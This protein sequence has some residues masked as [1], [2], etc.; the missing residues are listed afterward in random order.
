MS[1]AAITDEV[2]WYR[3]LDRNQWNTLIASNLGWMFDGYETFALVVTVGAALRQ[4]LDRSQY[5]DIPFYAGIVIGLTLLGWGIGG[6]I[7]GVLAD[8]LGRKRTML[9]AILAYSIMTG[10]SAFAWDWLSFTVLRFLV[11]IAIGSEWVTGASIVSELWP[12]RARG[13]GVGLMQ[14]GFGIGFF[15]ASFAWLFVGAMGPNGWRYMF[16]IGVSPALMTLWVRRAIPE[17]ERWERV[18]H[19]RQA[20][21]EHRRRG[22]TLSAHDEALTRFTM[23]DLFAEPEIRRRVVLAFVMSL[24]TTFG[25]WGIGAWI[26]PFVTEAAARAGRD[27]QQWGSYAAMAYTGASVLGYIVFGFLADAFGRKP[28]TMSYVVASAVSVALLFLWARDLT[29][30]LVGAGLCGVFVSGQYTW[31]AAWLPELFPTRMRATAAGFVFNTPRLIAWTG[32]LVS[33]WLITQAGGFSQAAMAIA[34]IYVLSLAAAPFLP[35]TRGK[36]LPG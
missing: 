1:Q 5:G 19:Q 16:L 7:G 30:M 23:A 8:Y 21:M 2:P 36:P 10:L 17:S 24:A 34:S 18:N 29:F 3:L 20:A 12:D 27:G 13:R 31:M 22:T 6:L 28:A 25:F 15:L 9:I 33:G 11:G 14:C 4:L 35:E 32:P 26:A